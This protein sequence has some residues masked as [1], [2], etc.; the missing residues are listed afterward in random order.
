MHFPVTQVGSWPRSPKLLSGLRE[1]RSG[2]MTGEEFQQLADWE[3]KRCV[4][5]QHQA[6]VDFVVDGELRR[7]NF[8]SF[9]TDKVEGT[10]LMSLAEMLDTV[11]DKAAFEE[12]LQTLDAPAFA[13]RNHRC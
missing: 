1:K 3:I 7:D 13:I 12:M 4:D 10:R 11:E 5:F 9:I 6:D 8:Y 2:R